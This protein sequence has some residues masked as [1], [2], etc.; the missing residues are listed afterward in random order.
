MINNSKLCTL[1]NLAL[2]VAKFYTLYQCSLDI[3]RLFSLIPMFETELH[4]KAYIKHEIAK[5][6]SLI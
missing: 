4:E 3:R 1:L 5:G 2:L 6:N